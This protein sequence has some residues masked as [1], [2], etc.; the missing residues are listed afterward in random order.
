MRVV[1]LDRG[2]FMRLLGPIEEILK[3]NAQKYIKF[4]K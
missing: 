3:R 1:C 4:I 2:S